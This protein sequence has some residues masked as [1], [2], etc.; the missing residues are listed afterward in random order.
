MAKKEST[1]KKAKAKA[2]ASPRNLI[3]S[4]NNRDEV[5]RWLDG[6]QL[7]HT[8]VRQVISLL[9]NLK[10]LPGSKYNQTCHSN[11]REQIL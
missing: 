10:Q 4:E 8:D 7:P 3:M 11:T 9:M 5:V 1:P 2:P 6:T